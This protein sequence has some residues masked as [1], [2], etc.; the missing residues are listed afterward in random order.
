MAN[1]RSL[2]RQ[3][4]RGPDDAAAFVAAVG[5]CTWLPLVGLD[6]PNLAEMLGE[7][8]AI[9]ETDGVAQSEPLGHTVDSHAVMNE[10]WYWKDDLHIERRI[11][12]AKLIRAQ[13]S[14]LAPDFLPDFIAALPA[15][16]RA[17]DR[18]YLDG[19]L[20]REAV[21]VYEYLRDHPAQ[22]TRA[23]RRGARLG[24]RNVAAATVKA[25]LEL[26]RRFVVCKIDVTGRT[27]GTYSYVWD[28]AERFWPE[29]FDEARATRP[30]LA[31]DRIRERLREMG[32]TPTPILENRLFGWT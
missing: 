5:F 29:A 30:D 18:L 7:A 14:F 25:L 21:L 2:Y 11:Y 28:L 9:A 32:I 24:T 27:R 8:P 31:R 19:R 3:R 23:L 4:V 16:E 6:F 15:E 22:P 26:Q 10:T 20:S 12:Y 17:P 13:P 1:W